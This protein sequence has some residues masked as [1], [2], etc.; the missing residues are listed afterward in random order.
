MKLS[1]IIAAAVLM[2][3][4]LTATAAN[5]RNA[6]EHRY[7]RDAQGRVTSR[8]AYAW[9]G[10]EWQPA[11]RW[12]YTYNVAGY[13]MEFSRY[14]YRHHCFSAPT[15]KTHYIFAPDTSIAYVTTF[16]RNEASSSYELTDSFTAVYPYKTVA[17]DLLASR[18]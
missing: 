16:T 18:P 8:T 5:Y 14:D 1:T 4:S 9:N 15:T 11:L 6:V 12:T 10:E 7:E 13:S 3:T 17:P 2:C